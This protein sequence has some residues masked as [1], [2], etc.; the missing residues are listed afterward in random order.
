MNSALPAELRTSK[1][2]AVGLGVA[3]T[4]QKIT[5]TVYNWIWGEL[6]SYVFA[7]FLNHTSQL[8][9]S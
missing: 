3:V 8:A 5:K 9:G 4:Q 7:F 2:A 6:K 1:M